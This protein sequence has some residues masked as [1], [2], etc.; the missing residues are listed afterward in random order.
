MMSSKKTPRSTKTTTLWNFVKI[1]ALLLCLLNFVK[2]A[3]QLGT[4]DRFLTL[5]YLFS[6]PQQQY[7]NNNFKSATQNGRTTVAPSANYLT[8]HNFKRVCYFRMDPK[9]EIRL[10][11]V[12]GTL[13]THVILAFIRIDPKGNL[14]LG[15]NQTDLDY[16][17]EVPEFKRRNPGVKVMVSVYNELEYNGFPLAAVDAD[18]RQQLARSSIKFLSQYHLDGIDLDWEFPN[19]PTNLIR[20]REYEKLGLTKILRSLRSAIVENFYDRQQAELNELQEKTLHH[21]NHNNF[22]QSQYLEPYLLTIAIA[23][24]ETVMRAAYELKHIANL[25]DW[26]NIMSYDYY[27]FKTYTPFTGPNSPL[28]SIV[29]S[30]VPFLNKLSW[31][32]TLNRLLIDEQIPA[33]KIVM[34]IP[35][36]ARAYRL[37]FKNSQPAPFTLAVGAKGGQIEDYLNYREVCDILGRPDTVTDFDE[38]GRV[39]YLLT[40]DGFTWISYENSQSVREKVSFILSKQVA[41]YMTWNLNSDDF[42]GQQERATQDGL[43]FPLHRAMLSE[44]IQFDIERGTTK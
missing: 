25:C 27:L 20:S 13:C 14:V 3:H 18:V 23:A 10:N 44:L 6:F 5:K 29:N 15:N 11:Q 42:V 40:D 43:S 28:Y 19:F 26:L 35:T 12:D 17:A 9:T 33:A 41:G 32:W 8:S 30:Q 2:P 38:R 22:K 31:E 36:Y 1:F 37:M 24:Q 34:G 21:N 4:S 7:P 39:P 16:L